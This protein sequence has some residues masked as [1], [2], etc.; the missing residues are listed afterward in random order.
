MRARNGSN[1]LQEIKVLLM[2]E[3]NL[4]GLR[5]GDAVVRVAWLDELSIWGPSMNA[6]C[7]WSPAN[8]YA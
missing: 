1:L 5:T 8:T 4:R 2:I 6:I 3:K 7:Q